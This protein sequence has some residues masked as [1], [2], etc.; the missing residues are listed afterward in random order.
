MLPCGP[1]EKG[2]RWDIFC[3]VVDNL[4]DAGVCWRLAR[5][6]VADHDLRVRLWIDDLE[7]LKV[8]LPSIDS[9]LPT[10]RVDGVEITRW[11]L[12]RSYASPGDVVIE[13]F[14]CTLPDSYVEAMALMSPKPVW[15]NLEYLSAESWTKDCHRLASPHPTLPLTKYFFFPGFDSDTGGLIREAGLIQSREGFTH[16]A[17]ELNSFWLSLGQ[18]DQQ[19]DERRISLFC[20]DHAPIASLFEAWSAEPVAT[21]CLVSPGKPLAAVQGF[22]GDQRTSWSLGHLKVEA[23]PFLNQRDYDRLL[24]AC[25]INFVR[26]EDS[27]V[28]AQWAGKPMV[29]HIYR[30][31]EEAHLEKLQAFLV[32]SGIPSAQADFMLAWNTG[33]NVAGTWATWSKSFEA[34]R[35]HAC[36][37]ATSL[38]KQTDL[39]INLVRF[40]SCLL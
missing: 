20:Y 33:A 28:R 8:L 15:I 36:K 25:D 34:S 10:Q 38:G 40:A 3:K 22:F 7:S 35:E 18:A 17:E 2:K 9:D 5:Q 37:W 39:A 32:R 16:S 21:R 4:G 24:W 14:A 27:F 31:D 12:E 6:L 1:M 29:W 19:R 13:A 26:G 11:Q 23:I 30:Q